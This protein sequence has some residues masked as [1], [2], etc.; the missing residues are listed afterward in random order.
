[1]SEDGKFI[2]TTLCSALTR[3]SRQRHGEEILTQLFTNSRSYAH[4][5]A[6]DEQIRQLRWAN[7]A[8]EVI[9]DRN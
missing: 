1:M 7:K 2:Y 6:T 8:T 9:D 5:R 3:R 4:Q